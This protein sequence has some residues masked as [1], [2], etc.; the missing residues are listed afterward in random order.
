M[1]N[2][3]NI[4]FIAHHDILLM[5]D[6]A[7]IQCVNKAKKENGKITILRVI[8]EINATALE[9][10]KEPAIKSRLLGT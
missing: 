3:M 1:N 10:L 9:V 6:S 5:D 2:S 7:F 8:E 4:L